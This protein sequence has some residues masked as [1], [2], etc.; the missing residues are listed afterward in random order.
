MLIKISV[1][2]FKSFDQKE[3]LSMISSS[4]I[5]TNKKHRIKIKQTNL[6]KNAVIYGANA[7]G[8]SNLVL[9]FAFI[10]SVL[11]EGGLSVD[12]IN[13]FCRN[14]E[15]NKTRESTFELQFTI[16]DKFYAYG[17]SAILNQRKITEEWM[18]ELMQ[19]GEARELFVRNGE[20]A[21]TLGDKVN[22]SDSERSRFHV[23]AEDFSGHETQLFLAE[24]NRGK[25]YV[26]ESKLLFFNKVFN[27][28]MRNIIIINPDIGISNTA[29][30][31]NDESLAIIS[32]LIQTFDTGITDIKTK[33][34]S[35]EELS[36]MLPA[37]I[38]KSI[39]DDLKQ[40]MQITSIPGIQMTWRVDNGFFNIRI[41]EDSEPEITTLVLKH[42]KSIFDFN[43]S[44]E[45][46]GT[47][48]LFDLVDMLLTDREDTTF[49]VDEL[50]R[51]LHP[52]LIEHFLN[53]FTEAHDE[54]RMQLIFTTHE[55]TIM[56]Q[57]LFRRDEI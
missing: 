43:F 42:G 19:N 25:K 54:V 6:L 39:F 23:Y 37:E 10:K 30:Y 14:K 57:R 3:E 8:K 17:F 49:I 18:Y 1:E 21:P 16:E 28:I 55:N 31:Y 38:I 44:E 36:K 48:R 52:N 11:R 12:C 9:A 35:I 46:D 4:K 26:K 7:S 2:N 34:V 56:D 33:E 53:L 40:Q 32:K 20:E 13:D 24:M 45:S 41:K 22:P 50:D 27:W 5:R 51:S 47:K 15:A 29:A